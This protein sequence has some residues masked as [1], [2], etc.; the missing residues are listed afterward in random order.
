MDG[1]ELKKLSR[2]D[3]LQMLI[4]QVKEN[5]R[6]KAELEEKDRLLRDRQIKIQ[7]C[8]SIAEAALKLNGVFEAAQAAAQQY[9]DNVKAASHVEEYTRDVDDI[10]DS[11]KKHNQNGKDENDES[12]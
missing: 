3:L 8:G 10:A 5:D 1:N 11:L 7:E 9:I 4:E 6:L 2:S 12:E